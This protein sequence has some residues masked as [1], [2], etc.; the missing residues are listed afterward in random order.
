MSGRP[1]MG[2]VILVVA[3]AALLG[4]VCA[5]ESDAAHGPAEH[6]PAGVHSR[7]SSRSVSW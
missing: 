4:H 6:R 1:L 7:R 3:L 2:Q 5:L